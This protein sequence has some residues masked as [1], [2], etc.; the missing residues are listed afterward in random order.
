MRVLIYNSIDFPPLLG[1]IVNFFPKIL[2]FFELNII[3]FLRIHWNKSLVI[4]KWDSLI[5]LSK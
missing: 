2:D 4:T 3:L 1:F 5:L